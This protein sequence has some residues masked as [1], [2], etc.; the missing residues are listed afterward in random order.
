[1]KTMLSETTG[2]T[3]SRS[4]LFLIGRYLGSALSEDDVVNHV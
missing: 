1:V 4:L 3:A 2:E